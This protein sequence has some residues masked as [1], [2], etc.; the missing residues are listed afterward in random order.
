MIILLL[1]CRLVSAQPLWIAGCNDSLSLPSPPSRFGLSF[2]LPP[3]ASNQDEKIPWAAVRS[4]SGTTSV[5]CL[6]LTLELDKSLGRCLSSPLPTR[7][8]RY[9][10]LQDGTVLLRTSAG[11]PLHLYR[12]SSSDFKTLIFCWTLPSPSKQY[13]LRRMFVWS[14]HFL[15][16]CS[17]WVNIVLSEFITDPIVHYFHI[18]SSD[19]PAQCLCIYSPCTVTLHVDTWHAFR[20]WKSILPIGLCCL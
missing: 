5:L 11:T 13:L 12:S 3:Q 6:S 7:I 4:Q 10:P 1:I 9:I 19:H 16:S 8:V 14:C 2:A 20:P 15:N 17:S 18:L